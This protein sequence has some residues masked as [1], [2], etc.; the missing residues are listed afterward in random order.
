MMILALSCSLFKLLDN[1]ASLLGVEVI[2][3]GLR[4][5]LLGRRFF[6]VDLLGRMLPWRLI[7]HCKFMGVEL[8]FFVLGHCSAPH[9]LFYHD[10]LASKLASRSYGLLCEK[11]QCVRVE[12]LR[13]A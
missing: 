12:I 8:L 13:L 7:R 2:L 1:L 3:F 6:T 9:T 4:V 10:S 5:K 11:A